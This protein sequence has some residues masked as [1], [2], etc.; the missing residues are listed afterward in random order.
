[1]SLFVVGLF[2]FSMSSWNNLR[3]V[4]FI[5][6]RICPYY[7]GHLIYC[8]T[9]VY[10]CYFCKACSNVSPFISDFSY[11]CLSFFVILT[12][13]LSSLL[14]FSENQLLVLLIAAIVLFFSISFISTRIV[15]ISFFLVSL[16]LVYSS[17]YSYLRCKVRLFIW[18]L[19]LFLMWVFSAVT[20]W[21]LFSLHPIHSVLFNLVLFIVVKY[22]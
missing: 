4:I 6:I 9:I 5:I 19:C 16:G 18:D 8:H 2:R 15:I 20:F 12:E 21:A 10:P 17:F 3:L 22:M 1:M 13:S 11:L 7:L 14:V